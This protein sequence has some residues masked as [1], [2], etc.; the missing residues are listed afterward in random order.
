VPKNSRVFSCLSFHPEV[1]TELKLLLSEHKNAKGQ[2]N[3]KREL[4]DKMKAL[5]LKQDYKD[6]LKEYGT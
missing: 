1:Q 6:D 2:Y 4:E 5:V 3:T